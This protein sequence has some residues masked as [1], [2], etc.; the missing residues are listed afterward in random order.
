MKFD[1]PPLTTLRAFES[2]ARKLSFTKASEELH[3][4]QSAVS[5][6]VRKLE[7]S[8]GVQLFVRHHLK[9]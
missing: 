2:A 5:F 7:T 8:L 4:T 1:L 3:L 9:K 6:Q